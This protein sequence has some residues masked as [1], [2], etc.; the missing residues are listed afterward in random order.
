[1]E[2]IENLYFLLLAGPANI[3]LNSVD[4]IILLFVSVLVGKFIG[5]NRYIGTIWATIF[6]FLMPLLNGLGIIFS[7]TIIFLSPKLTSPPPKGNIGKL[8]WATGLIILGVLGA[9]GTM[10]SKTNP[11]SPENY[12]GNNVILMSIQFVLLACYLIWIYVKFPLK[13]NPN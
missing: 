1:M 8:F 9:I 4:Y 10:A 11:I 6:F 7:L 3:Q 13:A 12:I 2:N 5:E